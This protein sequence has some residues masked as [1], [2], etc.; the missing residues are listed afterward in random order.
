[1]AIFFDRW[2][3]LELLSLFDH[4]ATSNDAFILAKYSPV[5]ETTKKPPSSLLRYEIFDVSLHV[6]SRFARL[7]SG[8]IH[9]FPLS[10][11]AI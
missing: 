6:Y 1:M 8:N 5:K 2:L 4:P 9:P 7:D 11:V 3:R 10:S